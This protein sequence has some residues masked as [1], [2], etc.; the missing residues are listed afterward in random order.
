MGFLLWILSVLLS[1]LLLPVGLL[2]GLFAAIYKQKFFAEGLPVIDRKFFRLAAA[3]DVLGN[4][5][6]GELFNALLIDKR[7][8]RVHFGLYKNTISQVLGWN[9]LDGT[10]TR[11]GKAVD[12]VLDFFDP[13]HSLKSIGHEK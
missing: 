1:A 3:I 2:Y 11:L 9:K 5:V 8:S 12:A 6:C 7:R 10:L 4:V 13:N